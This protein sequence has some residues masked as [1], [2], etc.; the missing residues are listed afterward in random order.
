MHV[1][2]YQYVCDTC[3]KTADEYREISDRDRPA[4][5]LNGVCDGFVHRDVVG[6][7]RPHTDLGYQSPIYSDALGVHPDQIAEATAR[8][9]DHKFHPDGRMILSSHTERNRV[10]KDLGYFDKK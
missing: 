5:C 6:S 4:G 8:F 7:M 2:I 1:P 9:P 10:L 3:G